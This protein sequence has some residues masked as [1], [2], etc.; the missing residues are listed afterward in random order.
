MKRASVSALILSVLLSGCAGEQETAEPPSL[1]PSIL[2]VTLDTTRAD[3]IGPN[4]V[5]V[6]TPS[7]NA[8]AAEGLRFTAA[9]TPVP[10]TLPAHASLMSGLY[11][12]GTG[13]HEN[14]RYV[15]GSLPLLAPELAERGY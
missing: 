12:A 5:G 11:P 7:F 6:E 10:E 14:A 1:G 4:A 2:L 8:I 3:A 15:P 9:F 13:I